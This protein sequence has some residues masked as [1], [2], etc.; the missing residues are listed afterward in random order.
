MNK[1]NF[2][3][4]TLALIAVSFV[5]QSNGSF[6]GLATAFGYGGGGSSI[7]TVSSAT[8]T[9]DDNAGT[10]SNVPL[11]TAKAAF[12]ANLTKDEANQTWNDAGIANPVVTGNSLVVTAQDTTTT[13]T[14]TVT[15]NPAAPVITSVGG[16][17]YINNDEKAAIIVQGTA[18][19]NSLVTV[20]LTNDG[21]LNTKTGTQQLTGGATNFSVTINGTTAPALVDGNVNAVAVATNALG[22]TSLPSTTVVAIKDIVYPTVTKLGTG[23]A[24][25]TIPAAGT[26]TLTFSKAL[27]AAGKTAV[28]NAL[29]IGANKAITFAWNGG[30]NV[31]TITGH[32]TEV[33]TFAN[34]VM[35]NVS[36]VAGNTDSLLLVDSAIEPTQVQPDNTGAAV[37]DN[38]TPQVVVVDP[39]LPVVATIAAGTTNPEIDVSSFVSGGTGTIP[40]ISIVSNNAGNV[41][42]DIPA[43]TTVTS[44]DPTWNG[45]IEAPTNTTISLPVMADGVM[46]ATAAVQVGFTGARLSFDNAVRLLIPGQG[47]KRAGYERGGV[48]TEITTTCAA[49]TQAAGNALP[50]NGDCKITVGADM[51]IWTKHFTKFVAFAPAGGGGSGSGG[52]SGGG[53]GGG[54]PANPFGGTNI[55]VLI[56]GG[57]T[58]TMDNN[59]TLNLFGGSSA[60]KMAISNGDSFM[61]SVQEPYATTKQWTLS[62]DKGT[63]KVCARFYDQYGY[64]SNVVCDEIIYGS[65]PTTPTTPSVWKKNIPAIDSLLTYV[66]YGQTNAMVMQLQK[67]LQAAGFF[68][69]GQKLTNYYG[70]ITRD[71]VNKYKASLGT[72]TYTRQEIIRMIMIKIIQLKIAAYGR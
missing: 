60:K 53:G 42:V 28:Q 17:G 35:A 47:G 34:D 71:A 5:G 3:P 13:M 51:V 70:D 11:S 55:S 33:T 38:T 37:V 22:G 69:A 36:D 50:A 52:S 57:A 15:V 59:V 31:L 54:T 68:P 16:N 32:A 29:T 1:F 7:A 39:A 56:N 46:T 19:A 2:I 40:A 48:F 21:G 20:T 8:Y 63:K 6:W 10:I 30:N 12:L 9:V 65:I 61:G 58:G 18:Q 23:A 49:D 25:Y 44:A 43:N 24:D 41:N 26:A 27:S 66:K 67:E 14:Y 62:G 64:F 4:V 72:P 45:V